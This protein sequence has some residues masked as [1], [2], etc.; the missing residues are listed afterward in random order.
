MYNSDAS[1]LVLFQADN[2]GCATNIVTY[3]LHPLNREAHMTIKKMIPF[4]LY[5]S[6]FLFSCSPGSIPLNLADVVLQKS[7][8]PSEFIYDSSLK[9]ID[10]F[11]NVSP[12]SVEFLKKELDGAYFVKFRSESPY[13]IVSNSVECWKTSSDAMINY[14]KIISEIQLDKAKTSGPG[15][16]DESIMVEVGEGRLILIRIIWRYNT[17]VSDISMIIVDKPLVEP[18]DLAKIVQERIERFDGAR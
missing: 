3:R 1:H 6:L 5:L 4:I 14:N 11:S 15:I 12:D 13:Q 17:Y 2:K 8:L 18:L 10:V 7:D 16:G 9:D